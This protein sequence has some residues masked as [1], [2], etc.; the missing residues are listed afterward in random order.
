MTNTPLSVRRSGDANTSKKSAPKAAAAKDPAKTVSGHRLEARRIP[1]G[2]DGCGQRD[3]AVR[4]ARCAGECQGIK[5]TSA[6]K[7]AR[8]EN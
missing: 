5:K 7:V 3:R 4:E 2:E 1:K 6:A 8:K